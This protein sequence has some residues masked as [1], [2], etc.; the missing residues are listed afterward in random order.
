M[1]AKQKII[2]ISI[3]SII[4]FRQFFYILK[5][6]YIIRFLKTYCLLMVPLMNPIILGCF[7]SFLVSI[8][9][10]ILFLLPRQSILICMN[11]S[12]FISAPASEQAQL[13]MPMNTHRCTRMHTHTRAHMTYLCGPMQEEFVS[14]THSWSPY[15]TINFKGK[16][17][18]CHWSSPAQNTIIFVI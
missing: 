12:P 6:N 18:Y 16:E 3:S 4:S 8:T 2:V 5:K 11:V 9:L 10:F 14:L 7:L 17:E 15:R 1:N 13:S